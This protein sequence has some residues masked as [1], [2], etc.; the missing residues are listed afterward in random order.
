[1]YLGELRSF[2]TEGNTLKLQTIL[3]KTRQKNRGKKKMERASAV[4]KGD[5]LCSGIV[6]VH[7]CLKSVCEE[8]CTRVC[9]CLYVCVLAI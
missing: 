8:V 4:R 2:L 3:A 5:K 7:S 6:S 1:M 9:I